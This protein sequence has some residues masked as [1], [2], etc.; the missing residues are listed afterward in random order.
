MGSYLPLEFPEPT[1]RRRSARELFTKAWAARIPAGIPET[2]D[3]ANRFP[4]FARRLH[5]WLAVVVGIQA[6]VWTL[7]GLYM[8]AVHIDII[9]GDHFVGSPAPRAVPAGR[10]ADPVAV[11]RAVPGGETLELVWI[12]D[13]PIYVVA[14]NPVHSRSMRGQDARSRHR[15]DPISSSAPTTGIPATKPSRAPP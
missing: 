14:A 13:R 9:H 6:A 10:L 5:K 4:L 2:I 7:G 3:L 11:T 12:M 1:E 15:R 8:T